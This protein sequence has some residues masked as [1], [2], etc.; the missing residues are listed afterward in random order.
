[1]P[2]PLSRIHSEYHICCMPEG[3]AKAM[4]PTTIGNHASVNQS[5]GRG[6]PP[7]NAT[8]PLSVSQRSPQLPTMEAMIADPIT[9]IDTN[10]VSTDS[11]T[12]YTYLTI[13]STTPTTSRP[14]TA[15]GYQPNRPLVRF[16]IDCAP[17]AMWPGQM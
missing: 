13:V 17:T 3:P 14:T 8:V 7:P 12:R 11:T 6:D 5:L 1:M 9:R 4:A 2:A 10:T 15:T 16:S